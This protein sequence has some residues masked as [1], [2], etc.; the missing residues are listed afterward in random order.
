MDGAACSEKLTVLD[1]VIVKV[2]YYN[3]FEITQE[4][5][6]PAKTHEFFG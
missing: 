6:M 3:I 1:C 2:Y 5:N 4:K